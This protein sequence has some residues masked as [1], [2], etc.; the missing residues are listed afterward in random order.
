MGVGFGGDGYPRLRVTLLE[1][2]FKVADR[3]F[4]GGHDA[5]LCG[6]WNL[7]HLI[8]LPWRSAVH[9]VPVRW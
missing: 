9:P 3:L 1:V 6:R 5:A 2:P 4:A 8:R 7:V